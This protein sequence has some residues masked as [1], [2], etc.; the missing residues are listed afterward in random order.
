MIDSMEHG[1]LADEYEKRLRDVWTRIEALPDGQ[2]HHNKIIEEKNMC[3]RLISNLR[4]D[5]FF[6]KHLEHV[7]NHIEDILKHLDRCCDVDPFQ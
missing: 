5:D 3:E 1:K 4:K 7:K 6:E 2:A